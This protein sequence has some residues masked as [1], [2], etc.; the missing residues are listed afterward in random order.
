MDLTGGVRTPELRRGS[1]GL[2]RI[3]SGVGP[4]AKAG[5]F[6][7]GVESALRPRNPHNGPLREAQQKILAL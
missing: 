2:G 1:E 5:G 7:K 3:F 6:L 4:R